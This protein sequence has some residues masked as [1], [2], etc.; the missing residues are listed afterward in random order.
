MKN[1][2]GFTLIEI[3]IVLALISII[4]CLSMINIQSFNG[5]TVRI[6]IE[7][8]YATCFYLQQKALSSQTKQVLKFDLHKG[9]YTYDNHYEELSSKV[10]YG[11][12]DGVKG[13]PSSPQEVIGKKSS[14]DNDQ[15]VFYPDGIIQSGALYLT[16]VNKKTLYALT[17]GVGKISFLRKYRYDGSWHLI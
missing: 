4:V 6:E 9:A 5:L 3:I 17:S 2:K 1:K 8:L 16:D 7:K 10:I 12:I 11:F 15:I 13:P 14:F